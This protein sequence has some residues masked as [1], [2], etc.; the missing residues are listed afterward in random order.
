M[1]ATD[2]IAGYAAVVATAALGWEVWKQ[3]QARRLR[4][5]VVVGGVLLFDPVDL[6]VEGAVRIQVRNHGDLA[7]RVATV[8]LYS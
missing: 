2:V 1:D 3:R 4:V 8:G 7:V 5:E 6:A